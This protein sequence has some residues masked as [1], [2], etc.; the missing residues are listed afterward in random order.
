MQNEIIIS[1]LSHLELGTFEVPKNKIAVQGWT[2]PRIIFRKH[3][4]EFKIGKRLFKILHVALIEWNK[5]NILAIVK[6]GDRVHNRESAILNELKEE[7]NLQ[8]ECNRRGNIK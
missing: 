7:Y 8:Y 4:L 6:I 3:I 2:P 1:L 5:W